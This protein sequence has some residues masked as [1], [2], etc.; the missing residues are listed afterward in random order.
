LLVIDGEPLELSAH[1][2]RLERSVRELYGAR[3]PAEAHEL[4]L[5]DAAPLATGRLRLTLTPDPHG[6]LAAETIAA[7]V[8][9]ASI[10]PASE[11]A[12]GLDPVVIP[13]GLGCHK[14][15]DRRG[16]DELEA[17]EGED[18]LRLLIDS[19]GEVLEASRA[20]VFAVEGDSVITPA[21]DGRILPGVARA[22]AIEATR[23][24]GL[25]LREQPLT[26]DGMIAAGEAFLT[27]AVRG[28]E[29]VRSIGD[30]ELSG[31]GETTAAI[32]EA[33]KRAWFATRAAGSV[34]AR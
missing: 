12:I 20:N 4:A 2:Q 32:A 9:P 3:L 6:E 27:G 25:Q 18:C 24:L 26:I 13:G 29:P 19:D 10:F 34:A 11:R 1:L 5:A 28:V 15:A 23:S 31:A 8:D 16:L 7:P 22:S 14:W 21:A 30:V 33:L 17:G